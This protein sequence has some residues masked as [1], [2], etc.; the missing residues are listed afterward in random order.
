MEEGKIL[1]AF[2]ENQ[3]KSKKLIAEE[4]GMSRRNLYQLFES[5]TLNPE[6]KQKFESYFSTKIFEQGSLKKATSISNDI[7]KEMKSNKNTDEVIESLRAQIK[8]LENHCGFLQKTYEERLSTLEAN[9][10]TNQDFLK[11]VMA[12]RVKNQSEY[13]INFYFLNFY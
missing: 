4:I 2:I 9:L 6:T 12:E 10:K 3:R 13:E 1:L 5:Q 11:A 8:I 7:D